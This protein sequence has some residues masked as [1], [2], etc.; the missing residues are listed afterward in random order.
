[1][2]VL[3]PVDDKQYAKAISDFVV[4]HTWPDNVEFKL[5]FVYESMLLQEVVTP[6]AFE[7]LEEA[8]EYRQSFGRSLI[9]DVG[10][11]IRLKFPSAKIEERMQEGEPKL[12]ILDLIKE[13]K[14]DLVVMGSHKKGVVERFFLGS[15]SLAVLTH[16]PCSVMTIKIPKG[17]E[18]HEEAQ[19]S[20]SEKAEKEIAAKL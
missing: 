1:M 5:L 7:Q 17:T 13:W 20:T 10:T 16:A 12:V 6:Q 11:Q 19:A 8:S 14:P 4:N 2:K 18:T 9:M 15:V 3:I